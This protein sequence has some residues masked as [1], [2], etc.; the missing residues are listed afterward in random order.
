LN[1]DYEQLGVRHRREVQWKAREHRVRSGFWRV[2][3]PDERAVQTSV[4]KDPGR[5]PTMRLTRASGLGPGSGSN[6]T[7]RIPANPSSQ[8]SINPFGLAPAMTTSITE[9]AHSWS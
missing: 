8:A 1:R 4:I 3:R 7:G 5:W 9:P 2:G 6:T